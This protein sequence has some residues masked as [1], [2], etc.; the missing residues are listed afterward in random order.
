MKIYTVT[1]TVTIVMGHQKKQTVHLDKV[2]ILGH[3]PEDAA[4]S[5]AKYRQIPVREAAYLVRNSLKQTA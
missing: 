3:T 5:L 2:K 1:G 4:K